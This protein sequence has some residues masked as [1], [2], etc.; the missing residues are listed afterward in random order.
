MNITTNKFKKTI[1]IICVDNNNKFDMHDDC[2]NLYNIVKQIFINDNTYY[3]ILFTNCNGIN[4]EQSIDTD[5][6]PLDMF[7]QIIQFNVIDH[8]IIINPHTTIYNIIN[9]VKINNLYL[10][11]IY[12]LYDQLS[13][14]R[15]VFNIINYNMLNN[16][17]KSIYSDTFE[18]NIDNEKINKIYSYLKTYE[19]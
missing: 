18:N 2:G 14:D 15:Y 11:Y 4:I 19:A 9:D 5:I 17:I 8:L 16:E 13:K 1:G 10:M 3:K 12:N 6:Y 7:N